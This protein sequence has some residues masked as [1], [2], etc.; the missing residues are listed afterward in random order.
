MKILNKNKNC[1]KLPNELK[2]SVSHA[3]NTN[4]KHKSLHRSSAYHYQE[5]LES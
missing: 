2:A 3:K 5:N 4:S 1:V